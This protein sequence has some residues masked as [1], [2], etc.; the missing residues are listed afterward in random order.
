MNEMLTTLNKSKISAIFGI[1]ACACLIL[2]ATPRLIAAFYLMYPAQVNKQYREKPNA[3]NLTH[4]LKSEMYAT[5][6]LDWFKTGSSWQVLT[7]SKVRQLRYIEASVR[8]QKRQEIYQT[9]VQGLA[10]S[11]VDPYS[12]YR[13]AT[14]EKN[15]YLP[16]N[17]VIHSLRLSCYAGRVELG[18]LLRR[19]NLLHQYLIYL[20]DEMLEILY[21]Q[22]RLSS[23][24]QSRDLITL[25]QQQPSL[26][27]IVH[28]ALQY[29]LD[30]LEKF[31]QLFEKIT[32]KNQSSAKR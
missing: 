5:S 29:D 7:L 16:A 32:H 18:L 12:W 6:A 15:L 25:V 27:P 2:A 30:H 24:L 14:I 31:L 19:V 21:D 26:M 3:V 13:L 11:P 28:E 22:I 20:D 1:L 9:S 23:L 17:K 8:Q 4:L 10:L